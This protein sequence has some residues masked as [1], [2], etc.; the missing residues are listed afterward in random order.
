MIQKHP[1]N[2]APFQCHGFQATR[3]LK[4]LGPLDPLAIWRNI[5]GTDP[6][7][8][9]QQQATYPDPARSGYGWLLHVLNVIHMV[10]LC[11][12]NGKIWEHYHDH[13]IAIINHQSLGYSETTV[14]EP[15]AIRTSGAGLLDPTLSVG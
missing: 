2:S 15:T 14:E 13:P 11:C 7:A 4:P 9:L 5:F 12:F 8:Q 6:P 3:N 1:K 10:V